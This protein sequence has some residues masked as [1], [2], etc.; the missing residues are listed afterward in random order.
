[1]RGRKKIFHGFHKCKKNDS[2][3]IFTL[4]HSGE[5]FFSIGNKYIQHSDQYHAAKNHG[6]STNEKISHSLIQT[7]GTEGMFD[8]AKTAGVWVWFK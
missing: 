2:N 3:V 5:N 4:H 1:M 6:R 7:I 8:M